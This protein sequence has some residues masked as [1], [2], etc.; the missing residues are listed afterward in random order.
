MDW[1]LGTAA[2]TLWQ[3]ARGEPLEGQKAVAHVIT[4][5]LRSGRWG[6]SLAEVC[7]SYAQFSG[8]RKPPSDP[9]FAP[10]CRL[11]DS[12]KRL[13]AYAALIQAALDGEQDPTH[14]AT[15]YH[16]RSIIPP[17]WVNGDI[18]KKIPPAVFCGQY[19]TQMFYKDV[20]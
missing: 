12:D 3:E 13:T 8:W 19:G 7:L 9:N 20:P 17:P 1:N 2:R 11:Q 15:H 14:G 10:A 4:N 6:H 18:D 5:R 16:A